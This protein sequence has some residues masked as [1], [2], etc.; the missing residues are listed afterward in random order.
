MDASHLHFDELPTF[1]A[2]VYPANHDIIEI[3]RHGTD[4]RV[5]F[6]YYC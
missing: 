5:N 6:C 4:F 1:F 3:G 2:K